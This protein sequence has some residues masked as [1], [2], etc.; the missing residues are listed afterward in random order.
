MLITRRGWIVLAGGIVAA[1]LAHRTG[2]PVLLVLVTLSAAALLVSAVVLLRLG[3]GIEMDRLVPAEVFKGDPIPVRLRIRNGGSPKSLFFLVDEPRIRDA[4]VA[5]AVPVDSLRAGEHREFRYEI[6]SPRRGVLRFRDVAVESQAPFGLIVSRRVLEAPGTTVILPR[7]GRIWDWECSGGRRHSGVGVESLDRSGATQEFFAVR[8]YRP[9]D[10][11]KHIHWK[12]TA[13][14][15]EPMVREFQTTSSLEVEVV[16]NGTRSDYPGA[17]GMAALDAVAELAATVS[18]E[19]LRRGFFV[20]LWT[21]GRKVRPTLQESGPAHLKRLLVELAGLEATRDEAFADALAGVVGYFTPRAAVIC[22]T[23]HLALPEL[24]PAVAG[25]RE[26]AFFPQLMVVEPPRDRPGEGPRSPEEAIL[27]AIARSGAPGFR[28]RS[29]DDFSLVR[30][31]DHEARR[32]GFR[33]VEMPVPA[34]IAWT[35][36]PGAAA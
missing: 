14:M 11:M 29:D 3:G 32:V 18:A 12:L 19:L 15:R 9:E 28:F 17:S 33:G 35:P 6:A 1:V 5:T 36:E 31:Y 27:S 25:L 13:K 10:P 24:A 8:E 21:L 20:R 26:R 22:V 34:G 16:V 2:Q 30:M 4:V 7:P 23:P